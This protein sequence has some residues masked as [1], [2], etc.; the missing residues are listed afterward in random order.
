MSGDHDQILFK[1]THILLLLKLDSLSFHLQFFNFF[2]DKEFF[3]TVF[4]PASSKFSEA[5]ALSYD[6][7]H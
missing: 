1:L 3:E 7:H 2:P 4:G 6:N 5:S